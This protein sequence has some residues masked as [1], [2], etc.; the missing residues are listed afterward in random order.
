LKHAEGRTVCAS[1][2]MATSSRL[3]I[4]RWL[5]CVRFYTVNGS[6]CSQWYLYKEVCR[7]FVLR[8]R[9]TLHLTCLV[10]SHQVHL[11]H[12]VY[13]VIQITFIHSYIHTSIHQYFHMFIYTHIHA[14]TSYTQHQF[15]HGCISRPESCLVVSLQFSPQ[16]FQVVSHKQWTTWVYLLSCFKWLVLN[17]GQLE[18]TFCLCF[19][20]LVLNNGQLEFTFCLVSSG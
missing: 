10:S 15:I 19:K 2:Q 6:I 13:T 4:N 11:S 8:R 14:Y 16:L 9:S 20:W 7:V 18:F 5:P 1:L 12:I 17:N 3:S